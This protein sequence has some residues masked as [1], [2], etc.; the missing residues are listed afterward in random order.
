MCWLN[1]LIQDGACLLRGVLRFL[2]L[3][4]VWVVDGWGFIW[5]Q[6]QLLKGRQAILGVS[7]QAALPAYSGDQ[8]APVRIFSLTGVF[9]GISHV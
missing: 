4:Q 7:V 3:G 2:R 6:F 5:V 8:P 1:L 9:M